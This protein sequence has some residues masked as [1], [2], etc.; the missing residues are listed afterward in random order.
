MNT[1]NRTGNCQNSVKGL[2]P[3]G[4][5]TSATEFVASTRLLR[6]GET[7]AAGLHEREVEEV[8]DNVFLN[9][10]VFT[11]TRIYGQRPKPLST[12]LGSHK[13][14]NDGFPN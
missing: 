5:W 6:Q 1:M 13:S 14:I 7:L 10:Q 12:N 8:W 4:S 11:D 2:K 3:L 9:S